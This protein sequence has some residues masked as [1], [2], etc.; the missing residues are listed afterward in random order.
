LEQQ[1]IW[2]PPVQHDWKDTSTHRNFFDHF[3]SL[4]KFNPLIP[5]NW[6]QFS[7]K[8]FSKKASFLRNKYSDSLVK[9]LTTVYPDIGLDPSKFLV[10][11][12]HHWESKDNRRAIF[13]S[14]AKKIGFDPLVPENWYRVDAK[15]VIRDNPK[16]WS[17][18]K[19]YK[20]ASFIKALMDVY[21]FI[22]LEMHKFNNVPQKY[23]A[24]KENRK[25]FFDQFATSK[26]FDPLVC[27]NWYTVTGKSI[28]KT[29][30]GRGAMNYYRGS[31]SNALLDLYPHIGLEKHR[32]KTHKTKIKSNKQPT[33][34]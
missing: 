14:Y 21:S 8:D 25:L 19:Y 5:E 26:G 6:Y 23:Y 4:K 30:G 10:I 29:K 9:A 16:M 7:S 2:K 18:L 13:E 15:T 11:P 12:R 17:L 28:A 31:V 20:H 1:R 3:A 34:T 33:I 27:E 24:I 22:G 32:F